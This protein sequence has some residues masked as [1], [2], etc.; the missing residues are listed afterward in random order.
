M[1]RVNKVLKAGLG[2][3]IAVV[4]FA[5]TALADAPPEVVSAQAS[6]LTVMVK[7]K[8]PGSQSHGVS[9]AVQASVLGIP[10]C[11]SAHV[12]LA[13]GQTA[14][15]PVAFLGAVQNIITVGVISD[16]GTPW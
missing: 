1:S 14:N 4:M 9:V 10:V 12:N 16:D 2:A 13:P 3:A 11:S 15:V 6:G 8:N 5:G 7:V